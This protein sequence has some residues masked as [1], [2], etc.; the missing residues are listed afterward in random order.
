M[1]VYV[2]LRL[3]ACVTFS[4][5]FSLKPMHNIVALEERGGIEGCFNVIVVMICNSL[6]IFLIRC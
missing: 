4:C 5:S 3:H 1:A 6:Q 2:G